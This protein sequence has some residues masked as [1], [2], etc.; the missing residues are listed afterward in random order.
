MQP[1]LGGRNCLNFGSCDEDLTDLPCLLL[2]GIDGHGLSI[3]LAIDDDVQCIEAFVQVGGNR[4]R[5][6][7]GMSCVCWPGACWQ[8]TERPVSLGD[9]FS[10]AVI[11]P[12]LRT[13]PFQHRN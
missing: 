5:T 4:D 12:Q 1:K 13:T 9:L 8:K 10:G 2:R 3:I 7:L 11:Q 6:G